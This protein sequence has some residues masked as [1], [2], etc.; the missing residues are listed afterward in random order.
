MNTKGPSLK[1]FNIINE[2]I[3]NGKESV[4]VLKSNPY[5]DHLPPTQPSV[6]DGD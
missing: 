6:T 5:M 1:G 2:G 3:Y 4:L